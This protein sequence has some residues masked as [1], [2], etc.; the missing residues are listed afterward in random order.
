MANGCSVE[1]GGS[2]SRN[3]AWAISDKTHV[4]LSVT[5]F[6]AVLGLVAGLHPWLLSQVRSVVREEVEYRA[7]ADGRK[8]DARLYELREAIRDLRSE[9]RAL[10][11][12]AR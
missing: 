5:T 3:G 11:G 7:T 9:V 4:R 12:A 10:R 1:N 2:N 6:L 8:L